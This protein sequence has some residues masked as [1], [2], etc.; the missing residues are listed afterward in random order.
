MSAQSMLE[1]MARKYAILAVKADK[2]GKAEDAINN[3]KKAIEILSQLIALYPDSPSIKVYEQMINEYKKRIE[4]LKEAV[5]ASGSELKQI[6][7]E[8]LIVKEKPKVSFKDIVGLDDVKEALREAII[9]PTKRP[10]LF[11]LGWPRG[12]LLYGPPGCGKTMIAAA[13]ANEIDSYFIQVDAASI[14]SKWLGEAEK[15]VAKVFNK[16]R[17]ISKKEE[18][19]VII[20]IDELDA[21][22]GIYNSEN[23]GEV[24]VRNQFL[25]EMDG[26][27]DKSENYKVYVIGATNKPWRLDE[28]FLRRFQKRIYVRLPDFQQ[29]LSLLQYYTSKIKMENVDLSKVAEMTEGYTASDIKDIVQAAHIRVVKEMF[30]NNLN[31]PRAVNIEDFIEVLKIRKP[32]VNQEMIKAYEAWH[33]KFKAL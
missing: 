4:V 8:D 7:I 22:L 2:E 10:D 18:K 29:R 24:R 28:P 23:G 12:I 14:M 26:L 11:P 17:E 27:Q 9:Y 3:Y 19:P 21:L 1:D 30:I 20:F 6:D 15:N 13:V 32:S 25:K 5:P 16:A 31:E 33:E